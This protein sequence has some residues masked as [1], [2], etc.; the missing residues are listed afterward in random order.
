M[1][2]FALK[3]TDPLTQLQTPA[4]L[5]T[6]P[7]T[8][9]PFKTVA[10]SSISAVS[11]VTVTVPVPTQ[12]TLSIPEPV[13][14]GLS[15]GSKAG[16]GIGAAVG[17]ILFIILGAYLNSFIRHRRRRREKATPSDMVESGL[18]IDRQA[19]VNE[20]GDTD[21]AV[22]PGGWIPAQ[23]LDGPT[24]IIHRVSPKELDGTQ[25]KRELEGDTPKRSNIRTT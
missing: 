11:P 3:K 24:Q 8:T 16:I 14:N 22:R 4:T 17:A 13:P 12:T 23:E 2:V 18:A 1:T 15:T 10:P 5:I 9:V 20:L 25:W 21:S 19:S 7:I 6:V